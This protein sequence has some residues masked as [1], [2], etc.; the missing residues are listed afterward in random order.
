M[1]FA[2]LRR[3][4]RQHD[5]A[6]FQAG[7]IQP[8]R[9]QRLPDDRIR[10]VDFHLLACRGWLRRLSLSAVTLHRWPCNRQPE[11]CFFPVGRLQRA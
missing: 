7:F 4:K 8:V 3:D 5:L 2:H 9:F 1:A 11:T 6:A 10:R